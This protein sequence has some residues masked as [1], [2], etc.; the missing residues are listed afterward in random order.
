MQMCKNQEETKNVEK[1]IY[2]C[3]DDSFLSPHLLVKGSIC[4]Q[5]FSHYFQV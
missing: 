1:F 2:L 4:M 5:L 3:I